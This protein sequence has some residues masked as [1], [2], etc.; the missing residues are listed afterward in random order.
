[1]KGTLKRKTIGFIT[2][3]VLI[4]MAASIYLLAYFAP[5]PVVR[6]PAGANVQSVRMYRTQ[7]D[8]TLGTQQKT[9]VLELLA[10]YQCRRSLQSYFPFHGENADYELTLHT[11]TE[12]PWNIVIGKVN[13]CYVSS[14]QRAFE[15]LS[16]QNLSAE[17][18]RIVG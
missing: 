10:R 11:E 3:A 4:V 18:K 14:D 13:I 6:D 2:L 9:A 16:A 1:M 17:L 15:I 7:Q 8:I 12:I 5:R